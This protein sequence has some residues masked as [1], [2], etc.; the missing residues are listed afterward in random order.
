[1][2]TEKKCTTRE[3]GCKFYLGQSE[4]YSLEITSQRAPR[5]CSKEVNRGMSV[6][7]V[8]SEKQETC[9]QALTLA[10]GGCFSL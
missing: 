7:N 4:D 8:I 1:M 3:L 5:I 6:Y 9:S 10:E 2:S